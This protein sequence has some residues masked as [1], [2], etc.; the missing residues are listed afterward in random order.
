MVLEEG[1]MMMRV[2]D[3]EYGNDCIGYVL[4]GIFEGSVWLH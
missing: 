4:I 3:L 2:V 1:F